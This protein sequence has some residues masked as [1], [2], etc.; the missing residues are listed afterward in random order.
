MLGYYN[1]VF[2]LDTILEYATIAGGYIKMI[3]GTQVYDA[4]M[5]PLNVLM[6]VKDIIGIWAES[7]IK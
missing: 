6:G 7:K 5:M 2:S 4:M 1:G 3:I